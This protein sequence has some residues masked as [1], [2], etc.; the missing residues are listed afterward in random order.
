MIKKSYFFRNTCRTC[1]SEDIS[2][3]FSLTPS[4]PGNNFTKSRDLND[5]AKVFP[6][7]LYFC[8]DCSHVQLGHVVDKR[9][10]FQ[11]DYSYV[12]ATSSV[13]VEH[14][15][16]YAT[17]AIDIL[18]LKKGSFVVDIGS[19]DGTCLKFFQEAGMEVLGIDPAKNIA[20]IAN[21]NGIETIADFFSLSLAESIVKD[22]G[23]ADLVTSHNACAH[24]DDLDEIISGVKKM[25]SPS[26]VFIMEVGYFL[27]VYKN[28]WFDT[29]YHEHLD[30][31]TISPL[32]KL[33]KRHGM[34]IF[35]AQRISPQGGSIRVFAQKSNGVFDIDSS[36]DELIELE[37]KNGLHE[38]NTLKNFGREVNEVGKRFR[39]LLTR[40]K[41]DG[42]TIAAYGAPT[43]ATTLCYHFGIDGNYIDFIVDDNPL[44]Q[45]LYSPG[46]SIPV[47]S[48]DEIYERNPDFLVILAW[49]FAESI[50]QNHRKYI[51]SG[52]SFIIPMPEPKI[53][54]LDS[55]LPE[56]L[57]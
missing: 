27:D 56:S 33:F 4:P 21:S 24:I 29:I 6:L 54:S 32:K 41:A 14:L 37:S 44:K 45:N 22:L 35:M 48:S 2:L 52:G 39:K 26:G 7:D 42:S 11:N 30:F 9:F 13:F 43:K 47:L 3:A 28:K 10:L 15:S 20:Q 25:L 51:E 31:H 40:I 8:N 53:I 34:E 12:S 16:D 36:V 38:I 5:S 19:N 18:D 55:S 57:E 49:N 1:L 17:Y 50:I 46:K 23:D